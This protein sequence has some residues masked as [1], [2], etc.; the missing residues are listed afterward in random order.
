MAVSYTHLDVYKRQAYG[1]CRT[2]AK[3]GW[4]RAAQKTPEEKNGG[5]TPVSYTHLDVYKRQIPCRCPSNSI[6]QANHA[7]LGK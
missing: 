7:P 6:W 4:H 3:T 5:A 1:P 2:T